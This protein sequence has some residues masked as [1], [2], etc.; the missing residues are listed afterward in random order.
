MEGKQEKSGEEKKRRNYSN[1][2]NTA[3]KKF[4]N[5][6]DQT[7]NEEVNDVQEKHDFFLMIYEQRFKEYNLF[8]RKRN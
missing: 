3:M 5:V 8:Y 1:A 4:F 6:A 7:K 2:I